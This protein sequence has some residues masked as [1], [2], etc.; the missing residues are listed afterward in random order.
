MKHISIKIKLDKGATMPTR[1]T[2]GSIGYDVTAKS[3]TLVDLNNN[4]ITYVRPADYD[5]NVHVF[6]GMGTMLRLRSQ[7][8]R[9]IIDTGV[10][11]TPADGYYVELVPNSRLAKTGLVYGNSFGVIDPDYTGSIKCVLTVTSAA[12]VEDIAKLMPP[13]VVGQLIIRKAYDAVFEQVD[14]LEETERGD[15]GF[16]STAK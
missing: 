6:D 8:K 11:V 2:D 16:G 15:G 1:A 10:H 3:A 4:K 14:E 13:N 9:I 7:I 5:R 12:T